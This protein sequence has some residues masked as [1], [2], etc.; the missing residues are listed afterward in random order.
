MKTNFLTKGL[1]IGSLLIV[2]P[3]SA[4]VETV[5]GEGEYVMS[6]YDDM[7]IAKLR[8]LDIAKQNALEKAGVYVAR[9][10]RSEN[11]TVTAM[12]MTAITGD[13]TDIKSKVFTNRILPSDLIAVRVEIICNVDTSKIDKYLRFNEEKRQHLTEQYGSF[14]DSGKNL[15]KTK[16]ELDAPDIAE[17][18]RR[19]HIAEEKVKEALKSSDYDERVRLCN[20]AIEADPKYVQAYLERGFAFDEK[21]EYD[22]AIANANHALTIEPKNAVAYRNRGRVFF[23]L[24]KY[25]NTI[26]DC[27]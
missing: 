16:D 8:A 11:L 26:S 18:A 20:E 10:L 17:R 7:E 24:K 3:C 12:E 5:R 27:N 15:S 13:T 22:K 14:V 2:S 25:D 1:I 9:Y 6:V 4:A 23:S 21:K 19:R